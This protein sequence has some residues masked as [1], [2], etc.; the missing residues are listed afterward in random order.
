MDLG[1]SV[2]ALTDCMAGVAPDTTT[3]ALDVM[4]SKGVIMETSA[5]L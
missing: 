1:Y 5:A 4:K 2:H 3:K